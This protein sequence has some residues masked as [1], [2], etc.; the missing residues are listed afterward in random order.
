MS[1]FGAAR[2]KDTLNASADANIQYFQS[3][4]MQ[5]LADTIRQNPNYGSAG[6]IN[7]GLHLGNHQEMISLL[8]SL[9]LALNGS[10]LEQDFSMAQWIN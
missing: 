4:N 7:I 3:K 6:A 9:S 10:F 2:P 5:C 1:S 8:L